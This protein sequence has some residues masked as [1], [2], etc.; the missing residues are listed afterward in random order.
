MPDVVLYL[1][2]YPGSTRANSKLGH[3][4]AWLTTARVAISASYPC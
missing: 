3:S 2:N 1:Q 4:A